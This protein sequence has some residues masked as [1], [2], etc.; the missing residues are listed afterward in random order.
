MGKL[1]DMAC[2]E[3]GRFTGESQKATWQ[4]LRAWWG[5]APESGEKQRNSAI[6]HL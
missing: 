3:S 1:Q 4:G 2:N 6:S 5:K